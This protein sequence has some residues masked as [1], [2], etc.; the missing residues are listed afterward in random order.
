MSRTRSRPAPAARRAGYVIAVVVN[1]V[2]LWLVDVSPGWQAV[3]FLTPETEQVIG[4]VTLSLVVSI[5]VNL[6]YLA[7]D[8]PGLRAAGE[9]VTA[10]VAVAVAVRVW[11]VFPFDVSDGWRLAFRVLLAV[12]IAGGVIGALSQVVTMVRLGALPREVTH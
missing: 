7:T 11:Q 6:V 2:L 4:L 1:V 3:P 5:V 10:L 12:G 8:P 9:V